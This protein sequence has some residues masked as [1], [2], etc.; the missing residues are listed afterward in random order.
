MGEIYHNNAFT[1]RKNQVVKPL[2][3][4]DRQ[5]FCGAHEL[6]QRGVVIE[7]YHGGLFAALASDQRDR[8]PCVKPSLFPE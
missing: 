8:Q 4:V 6:G 1:Q 2:K 5:V 3:P 7:Q